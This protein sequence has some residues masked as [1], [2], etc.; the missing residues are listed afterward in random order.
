VSVEVIEQR[1]SIYA[2]KD[3]LEE[4]NALKEITQEIALMSLSRAGFFKMAEFHGGTALRILYHVQRYSEDLDFALLKPQ[5]NFDLFQYLE[6]MQADFEAYGYDITISDRKDT[7]KIVQKQFL[8]VD[9]LG[10]EL[11]LIY[12]KS[13]SERKIKIKFE[14]DTNPPKG[15]TTELKYLTFPLAF[16]LLAKDLPS[17]FAGKCHA[18]LC[19]P[20]DKGRDW[21]DFIWF[22][23]NK[24]LINYNLLS[25][26]INQQGPWAGQSIHINREWLLT[27]LNLKIREVNWTAIV[28]DVAPL[29]ALKEQGTLKLWGLDFFSSLI[30][31]IE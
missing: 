10:K 18:L 6:H 14:L 28:Q 3:R 15:A 2:C 21:Y 7:D 4:I 30:K 12:P 13:K 11:S 22:V 19:R 20:F 25:R 23:S 27:V 5:K 26:A 8:K 29:L 16:S 31:N 17:L 9:S 1:L 24:V